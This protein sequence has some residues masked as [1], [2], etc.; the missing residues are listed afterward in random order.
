MSVLLK[1]FAEFSYQK[2][3]DVD[4]K[5]RKSKYGN[6]LV[7]GILQRADALNQNGRVYPR[8][9]LQR[10]IENYKKL[11]RERRATGELDH[12]DSS[13]VNLK[14]VSH[15]ITDIWWENNDVW[16]EVEVLENMIQGGQLKA[17]FDSDIKVG[18]SSRA[19]GSVRK[20]GNHD[21]VQD[22][23]QLLCWDFVSE[24]S[25]INAFMMAESKEY[26]KEELSK[27][28]NKSDRI[29]RAANEILSLTSKNKSHT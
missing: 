1:E 13:V 15:V 5:Y 11:I 19:L 12:M 3:T 28:F 20:N 14:N 4:G 17:L 27:I 8:D 25:T 2:E 10:E 23:L 6:I 16:G 26:S 29:D 21:V 9:I 7:K 18:I 22:D 24:P